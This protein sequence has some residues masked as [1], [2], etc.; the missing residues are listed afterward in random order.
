MAGLTT[1][2]R[3]LEATHSGLERWLAQRWPDATDL[4]L[5]PLMTTDA[6]GRSSETLFL[7]AA[8]QQGGIARTASLVARMP[9]LGD[10]VFAEYDI[11]REWRV[12][13]LLHRLGLPGRGA[14]R[15]RTRPRLCGFPVP[16][17]AARSGQS[18]D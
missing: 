7:D 3:D 12:Q 8:F 13:D 14:D 2:Q 11:E 15:L 18:A 9:P 4:E 17:H 6:S 5:A 1:K 10:G 16:C